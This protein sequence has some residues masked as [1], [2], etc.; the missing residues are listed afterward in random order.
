MTGFFRHHHV[1]AKVLRLVSG[2]LPLP[3][4][5]IDLGRVFLPQVLDQNALVARRP[6][7]E[8]A[9]I[10]GVTVHESLVLLKIPELAEAPRAVRA[11]VRCLGTLRCY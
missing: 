3:N 10:S 6:R 2:L 11:L 4:I 5:G 9:L 7:A 8:L 1:F